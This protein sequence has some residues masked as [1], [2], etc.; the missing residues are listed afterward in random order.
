MM[1]ENWKVQRSENLLQRWSFPIFEG[2]NWKYEKLKVLK[3]WI[4]K[5]KVGKNQDVNCIGGIYIL[6]R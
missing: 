1:C 4:N 2:E 5:L 3:G 6:D